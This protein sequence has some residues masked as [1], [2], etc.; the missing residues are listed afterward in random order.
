VLFLDEPTT[1]LDPASRLRMWNVI[2]NLVADGATLLLTTQY[3]EEADE[4]ADRILVVD[5]GRAIAE[6]TSADLKLETGGARL[7]VTLTVAH[8]DAVR[9]VE[10]FATGA[11]QS[12]RDG[13]RLSAPVA[14]TAG[15]ATTVVR[16]LDAASISVDNVEVHQPSLDD[17]FFALTGHPTEHS[18]LEEAA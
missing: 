1:G 6:G 10:Q 9:A 11:V 7:D 3:L 13:R 15:L 2:R 8:A 4:L 16:A 5:H 14:T 12:S 17:V 18:P